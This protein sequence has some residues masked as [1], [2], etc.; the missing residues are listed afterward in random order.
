MIFSA[1]KCSARKNPSTALPENAPSKPLTAYATNPNQYTAISTIIVK[2]QH[3]L[4]PHHI[5]GSLAKGSWLATRLLLI[6]NCLVLRFKY[7]YYSLSLICRKTEGSSHR[8]LN[9]RKRT[10]IPCSAPTLPKPHYPSKIANTLA[11]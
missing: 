1:G 7:I 11:I 4:A 8:T 10:I 6:I 2:G 9:H 3:T 5:L